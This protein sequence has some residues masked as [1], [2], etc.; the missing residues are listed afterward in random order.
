MSDYIE[1]YYTDTRTA[2][3]ARPALAG[4]MEAEVCVVGGGLAGLSGP[5]PTM[6]ASLRGWTKDQRRAVFQVFNLSILTAA[7]VAHAFAGLMTRDLAIAAA[8]ALPFTFIGAGLGVALYA[9]VS[10]E[11]FSKI[12]LR[13]NANLL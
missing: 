4:D 10:E 11:K 12:I 3:D 13:N 9:R 5:L 1:S 7:L 6:W 8:T 2:G